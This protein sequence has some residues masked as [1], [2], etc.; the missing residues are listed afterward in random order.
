VWDIK[1]L[2]HYCAKMDLVW[3]KGEHA[4][5]AALVA[6]VFVLPPT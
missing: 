5:E 2:F 4:A 3:A 6:G 1:D